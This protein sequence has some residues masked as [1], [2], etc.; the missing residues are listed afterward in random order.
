[1]PDDVRH[2]RLLPAALPAE[3]KL[4]RTAYV[5][6]LLLVVAVSTIVFVVLGTWKGATQKLLLEYGLFMTAYMAY[7]AFWS[8]LRMKRRLIKYWGTY[9]LE[10]GPDYL[11][12][13]QADLP[14]LRLDF[15]EVSAVAHVPGRYLRVVG[16]RGGQVISI[17]EGI[18]QFDQVLVAVSSIRPVELQR[19][20]EWQKYRIFMAAAL[21]MFVTMLWSTSPVVVIPLSITMGAVIVWTVFWIRRNPNLRRRTKMIAW[22][23]LLFLLMCGLKLLVAI[24]S[25][26]PSVPR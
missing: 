2:Y 9:D 3:E 25:I 26:L 1:M 5:P 19:V 16:K 21:I 17:P 22:F 4:I 15:S 8:P 14:D 10:M 6:T 24:E 7:V 20:Q 12:R 18:E 11:L 13:R 23:Y